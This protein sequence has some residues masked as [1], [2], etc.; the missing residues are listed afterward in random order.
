MPGKFIDEVRIYQCGTHADGTAIMCSEIIK[1]VKIPFLL[2][3]DAPESGDLSEDLSDDDIAAVGLGWKEEGSAD[4][5]LSLPGLVE[6]LKPY[7]ITVSY[8]REDLVA[9]PG[10]SPSE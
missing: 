4:V 3:E 6:A 10:P 9:G 1:D 7:G 8:N 2:A 5:H